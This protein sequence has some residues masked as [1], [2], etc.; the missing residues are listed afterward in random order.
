MGL[1][2]TKLSTITPQIIRR[3]WGNDDFGW[4][5][6]PACN[7]SGGLLLI[8]GVS[9]FQKLSIRKGERWISLQGKIIEKNLLVAIVLAYGPNDKEGRKIMWRE[10]LDLK[11]VL[12]DPML[13]IGDFN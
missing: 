5:D 9:S 2:E 6:I 10:L 3:C 8:W 13:V 12:L 11:Q 7:G 1:V 4:D